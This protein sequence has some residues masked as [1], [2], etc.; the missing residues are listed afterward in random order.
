MMLETQKRTALDSLA[1][2]AHRLTDVCREQKEGRW[3]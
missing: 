3:L 1:D 2:T